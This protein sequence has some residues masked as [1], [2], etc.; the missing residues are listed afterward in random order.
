MA[1]LIRVSKE[2]LTPNSFGQVFAS[3]DK[4]HFQHITGIGDYPMRRKDGRDV[5]NLQFYLIPGESHIPA[6]ISVDESVYLR[7]CDYLHDSNRT[8]EI[9]GLLSGGL[10]DQKPI[11]GSGVALLGGRVKILSWEIERAKN[12]PES[13]LKW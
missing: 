5:S 11:D 6:S 9:Q 12:P 7:V 2:I 8:Y 1:A 3:K 4:I 13:I 10:V